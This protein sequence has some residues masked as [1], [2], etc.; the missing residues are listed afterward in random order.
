M[1]CCLVS[2]H[3]TII[4]IN[5]EILLTRYL[6]TN[7]SEILIQIHTVHSSAVWKMAANLS[8][9]QCVNRCDLSSAKARPAFFGIFYYKRQCYQES[10]LLYVI[11]QFPCGNSHD[12]IHDNHYQSYYLGNWLFSSATERNTGCYIILWLDKW[13]LCCQK[14]VSQAGI[15]Y[16]IPQ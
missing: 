15:S 16:Y 12:L 14:Q 11:C 6:G 8:Q 9:P 13:G 3:Q 7:V 2:Q 4:W 1:A 10:L 5:A